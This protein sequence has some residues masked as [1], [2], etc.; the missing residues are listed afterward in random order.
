MDLKQDNEMVKR[1][2]KKLYGDASNTF[3]Y[4][5]DQFEEL[6]SN[7]NAGFTVN[8]ND[9]IGINLIGPILRK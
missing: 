2:I 7:N 3:N 8:Y 4:I 9:N 1:G 5:Y 6:K